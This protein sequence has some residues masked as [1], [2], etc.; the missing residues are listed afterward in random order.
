MGKKFAPA[1]ANI[2]MADWEET[3]LKDVK[4]D[5]YITIGIWM[6]SGGFGHTEKMI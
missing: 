3:A 4:K 2:Y 5:P 1:Y 6:T